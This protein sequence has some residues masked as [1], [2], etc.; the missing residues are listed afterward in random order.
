MPWDPACS[1]GGARHATR[2]KGYLPPLLFLKRLS[3]VLGD[4]IDRLTVE[5]GDRAI[6]QEIAEISQDLLSFYDKQELMRS[7]VDGRKAS[8]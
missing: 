8:D 6:A 3:D 4:E 1:I 2:F 7:V 5:L